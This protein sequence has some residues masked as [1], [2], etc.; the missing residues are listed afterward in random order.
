FPRLSLTGGLGFQ[1]QGLGK[2]PV[3]NKFIWSAGP[4]AYWPF[5]DFGTLDAL[6]D[7][8]DLRTHE[9]LLNY[10]QTVLGAVEDV[11]TA[12]DAYAAQ[13]DRL[14]YLGDALVA[15]KRA[16]KL[17][18]ERYERGLTDFLNVLDAER[19]E[20][21]L[22]DQYAAAQTTAAE[23]FVALYKGLGGGWENYQ[24]IPPIHQPQP[25]ALAVFQRLFTPSEEPAGMGSPG[26]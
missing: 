2:T 3:T 23:Q 5:L 25:A 1:G 21:E 19:Q 16:L 17:A 20:Y 26:K 13:A 8:E 15:S 14:R 10:K 4:S 7:L 22:E 6:V 9:L 11:D 18:S 12:I 24:S